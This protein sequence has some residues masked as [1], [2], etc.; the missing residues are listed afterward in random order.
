MEAALRGESLLAPRARAHVMCAFYT[1][2][3]QQVVGENWHRDPLEIITLST[4]FFQQ[5]PSESASRKQENFAARQAF[6]NR[7]GGFDSVHPWHD[8][9]HNDKFRAD[10]FGT[11]DSTSAVICDRSIESVLVHNDCQCIGDNAFT[12]DDQHLA[13]M[14]DHSNAQI[15][16]KLLLPFDFAGLF[17]RKLSLAFAFA[18]IVEACDKQISRAV[19]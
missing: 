6:A 1:D 15:A 12:I 2:P 19:M 5:Q 8:D 11:F 10:P 17:V 13:L 14:A 7:Y 18:E 9:T 3:V 4:S 16:R